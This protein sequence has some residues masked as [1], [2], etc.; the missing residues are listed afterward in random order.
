[1]ETG[2]IRPDP[3][4]T[5]SDFPPLGP[6]AASGGSWASERALI[7]GAR[8]IAPDL[9]PSSSRPSA[10]A[11]GPARTASYRGGSVSTG[12]CIVLRAR[13]ANLRRILVRLGFSGGIWGLQYRE[14]V[15]EAPDQGEIR[16][17]FEHRLGNSV[18]AGG[19]VS[20]PR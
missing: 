16:G 13:R 12:R 14:E 10:L 15:R 17:R 11:A 3:F 1:M 8:S 2:R 4:P 19:A 5:S 7:A 9:L 18:A 6:A 20:I